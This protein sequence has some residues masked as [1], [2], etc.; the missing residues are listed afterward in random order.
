[1]NLILLCNVSSPLLC[2]E[3][4]ENT[5]SV[6]W[7]MSNNSIIASSDR[8][9]MSVGARVMTPCSALCGPAALSSTFVCPGLTIYRLELAFVKNSGPLI[10]ACKKEK[11]KADVFF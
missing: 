6:Q 5:K 3:K 2:Y 11:N 8:N 4:E 1:M 9:K 7:S 10:C